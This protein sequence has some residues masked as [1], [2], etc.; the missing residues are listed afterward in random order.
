MRTRRA[1]QDS[2]PWIT[3]SLNGQG[4]T[5]NNDELWLTLGECQSKCQHIAVSLVRPDVAERLHRLYLARG[6]RASVAIE[7]N[8][9]TE[10]QA[11]GVV[12]GHANVSPAQQYMRRELENIINACNAMVQDFTAGARPTASP[13]RVKELNRLV[14]DGTA[15]KEGVVP[16]EIPAHDSGVHRYRGAPRE[17]CEFLLEELCNW[18]NSDAFASGEKSATAVAILKAIIAHIYIAWIHPFGDGNGRT[19]R[20]LEFQILMDAGV[21]APACHLLSNHYNHTR[22]EYYTRLDEASASGGRIVPFCRY[23]LGGM[24][25]GLADQ[26]REIDEYQRSTLWRDYVNTQ[27][28]TS[29]K[30][31]HRQR[32]IILALSQKEEAVPLSAIANLTLEL[33][34]LYRPL[35][36]RTLKRDMRRLTL[37]GLVAQPASGSYVA[38]KE[39]LRAF[40]IRQFPPRPRL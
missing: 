31:D 1:Y 21:P 23:A 29:R 17:D 6:A 9:L 14:L 39:L 20:L 35:S 3:F 38:N 8:E 4:L 11:I 40:R 7:G 22:I 18:L 24:H 12:E 27:L 32:T 10:Q 33:S 26:I 30:S 34:G 15:L 16:G 37:L 13:G 36:D 25:E 2:H 5:G 19:A 28:G